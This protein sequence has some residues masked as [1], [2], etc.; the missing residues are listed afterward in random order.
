MTTPP[1]TILRWTW[2]FRI[3][4]QTLGYTFMTPRLR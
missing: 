2:A 1:W 3:D 4:G